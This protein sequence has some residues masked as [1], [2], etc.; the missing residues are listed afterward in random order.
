MSPLLTTWNQLSPFG[1]L[2]LVKDGV[3]IAYFATFSNSII[4]LIIYL[5]G[6]SIKTK[7]GLRL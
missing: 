3:E 5:L 7:K 2:A 4:N 1:D 6:V